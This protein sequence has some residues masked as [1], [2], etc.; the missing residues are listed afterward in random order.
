[1]GGATLNKPINNYLEAWLPP[2]LPFSPR[3]E[4]RE[5]RKREGRGGKKKLRDKLSFTL[6]ELLVGWISTDSKRYGGTGRQAERYLQS[7]T[8]AFRARSLWAM[9]HHR[10]PPIYVYMCAYS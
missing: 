2:A 10:D 9:H 6:V 1:M 5:E 7:S 8:R 4:K 3:G